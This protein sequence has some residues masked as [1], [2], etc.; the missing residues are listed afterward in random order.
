MIENVI[1][2]EEALNLPRTIFVDVRSE[3]EFEEANIPESINIPILNNE[4]RSEVG[5]IYRNESHEKAKILGLRYASYKLEEIYIKILELKKQYDN[6][7]FYCWRG[8]MR[9]KSVCTVLKTLQSGNIYRLS[10]G[11]KSYRK[12]VFDYFEKHVDEFKFIVL[13]GLTGV[14]KTIIID[15]L[16]KDGIS[17]MNLEKLAKNSG[18]VFGDI[19]F[20]GKSPSQKQFESEV[21]NDL[22]YNDKKYVI[23]ESESKRIGS[24]NV[25]DQVIK[26]MEEGYHILIETNMKNRV[27]NI[28]N[29]YVKK[30]SHINDKLIK[31]INHL[32]KRL[33]NKNIEVLIDKIHLGDYEYVIEFLIKDYYDPLYKYSID[34]INKTDLIIKYDNI[35][36]ATK[37]IEDFINEKFIERSN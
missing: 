1:S 19:L 32:N 7:V 17:I 22:Y 23:V 4:E 12:F 20:E 29:D 14:G 6:I 31:C 33:G 37:A 27:Y 15:E 5:K 35:N 36:D 18:S 16:E 34:R 25:P 13:H 26:A 10:G 8:G 2:I 11:Y 30:D 3:N 24:I 28:Y 9:S 21:F